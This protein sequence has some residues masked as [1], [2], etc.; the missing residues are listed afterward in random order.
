MSR[1]LFF[2]GIAALCLLSASWAGD[3]R[4]KAIETKR[5]GLEDELRVLVQGGAGKNHPAVLA[6][7]ERIAIL[8]KEAAQGQEIHAKGLLVVFAKD[9]L[10]A[11]LKDP[12]IRS[13]G[14]RTFVVGLEVEGPKI[15]PGP[16]FVGKMVWIP[17]DDVVQMVEV[18]EAK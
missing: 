13:L 9:K 16:R 11:T 6:L 5:V 14:G 10:G 2:V 15:T 3:E 7:R 18:D 4:S 8:V 12:R 1:A 17:L